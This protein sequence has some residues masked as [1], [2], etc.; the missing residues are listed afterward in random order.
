MQNKHVCIDAQAHGRVA[1]LVSFTPFFNG[2][3][4]KLAL[5][6]LRQFA[7]TI[8]LYTFQQKVILAPWK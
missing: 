6:T 7:L 1:E 8:T 5:P 3:S 2:I 4:Y